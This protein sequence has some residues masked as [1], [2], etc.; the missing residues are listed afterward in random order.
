M[1]DQGLVQQYPWLN[2]PAITEI[3]EPLQTDLESIAVERFFINWTLYPGNDGTVPGKIF[4]LR[5][6]TALI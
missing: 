6:K 2:E 3:P 4:Q 5:N 1:I